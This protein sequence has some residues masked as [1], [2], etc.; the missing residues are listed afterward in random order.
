MKKRATALGLLATALVST[1]FAAE[2]PVPRGIPHLDHVFLIMM[3]NHGYGQI[4]NNPNAPFINQL[5]KSANLA[6]NYFA[7]GH[8]SLTNYLE[9]VG[10]SNF[11]VQ[12][13]NNPD[14]HNTGCVTNLASG[15]AATDNPSSP[16]VC[17]IWGTGTDAATP[18]IDT[19][20]ETQGLPGDNN[21]DGI[22]SV[23]VAAN[24]VGKTIADQ[25]VAWGQSWKSYQESLPPGGADLV[26][27]S[28]GFFTNRTDFSQIQ[29]T[30]SPPLSQGDVVALYAVK[31]VPFLYFRSVQEGNDPRNSMNN[32]VDFEGPRGLFAD[33][34]S[35]RVPAFSFIAPNQC[36]DQHGRG[37]GGA[38]C[39]YDPA[40]NGTQA[41]LNPALIFRGDV[42]MQ[43]LVT[44]IK[45]SPAWR[46]GNNAI[47]VVW[48]E[49]DYS[50]A[51]NTNQVVLIVDTNYGADGVQ[52][53][54]RYTHFS[55]LK[56]LEAGFGLPCLNHACDKDAEVMSDLFGGHRGSY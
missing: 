37:N 24:T 27:Y 34:R 54:K 41:G 50:T 26:N 29:P 51:P 22:Q 36:N 23:P 38:F 32:I 1:A 25:L 3:E 39:N 33:L 21:I 46:D 30:L 31:H 6:T 19:T 56:S 20:N 45:S 52:S 47:V 11:G 7:V 48:D 8:P 14:W 5:A 35:G 44:S 55:L 42:T 43:K 40:S 10:G 17:P 13:D 18:A 4:L 12:T 15:I 28:D 53:A 49:N 9:V 2:G 16:S